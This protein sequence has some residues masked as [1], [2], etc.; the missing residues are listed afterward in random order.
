MGLDM[1]LEGRTFNWKREKET[2][3]G[4]PVKGV[5][6]ELGYWRK[7]PNLHGYIVQQFAGGKDECQEI[8]LSE[9]QIRQ[10][11]SA[12]KNKRLPHTEGFFFGQSDGSEDEETIKI[13]ERA[14]HWLENEKPPRVQEPVQIPGGAVQLVKLEDFVGAD[15]SRYVVYRASW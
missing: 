9:D 12:V 14:L 15:E 4:F 11:I 5:M 8:E 1:Y 2:R 10:T 13:L 6:L 3:D 7:H